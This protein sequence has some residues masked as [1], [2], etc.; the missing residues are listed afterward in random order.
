ME[1]LKALDYKTLE[2]VVFM[3]IPTVVYLAFVVATFNSS[4]SSIINSSNDHWIRL[5]TAKHNQAISNG[6]TGNEEDSGQLPDHVRIEMLPNGMM[7]KR[8][9]KLRTL[10]KSPV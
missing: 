3:V 9:E 6:L 2:L 4:D 5:A 7:V 1:I 8:G 10:S